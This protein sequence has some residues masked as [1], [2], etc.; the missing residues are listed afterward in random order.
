MTSGNHGR[1]MDVDSGASAS[2]PYA[3]QDGC[4][5]PVVGDILS[6]WR[7]DISGITPTMRGD[8]EE[9]F[10]ECA[11]CHSRQRLHRTVDVA[12]IG[13]TTISTAAFVLA[14][15]IIHHVQ[16]LQHWALVTLHLWQVPIVL[17]LRDA[18]ILGL[19]VSFLCWV[20]VAIATPAP[21]FLTGVA[22]NQARSLQERSLDW[23]DRGSRVA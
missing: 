19:F 2:S 20:L 13:L 11:Y 12:L 8:Y 7:Y 16:P 5:D 17:S 22:I 15:A 23:R 21:M 10:H 6:S 3:R 18:A 14:L 4:V 1:S 9:H